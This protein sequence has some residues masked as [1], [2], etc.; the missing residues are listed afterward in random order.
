MIL[1]SVII[2]SVLIGI[3][4]LAVLL[5]FSSLAFILT[6]GDII[7]CICIIIFLIKHFTKRKES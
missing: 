3:I 4:C 2:I 6:F 5:G 7:I 1:L